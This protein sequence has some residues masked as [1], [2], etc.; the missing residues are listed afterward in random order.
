MPEIRISSPQ[1]QSEPAVPNAPR[2]AEI[3][4][5]EVSAVRKFLL[6]RGNSALVDRIFHGL[7]VV[8]ALSIFVIV[9]LIAWQLVHRS[10]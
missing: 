1:V 9:A 7:M 5:F 6:S 8:C 3:G 10:Q 2:P 4:T